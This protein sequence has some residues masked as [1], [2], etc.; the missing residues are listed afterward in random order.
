MVWGMAVTARSSPDRLRDSAVSADGGGRAM[1][2]AATAPAETAGASDSSLGAALAAADARDAAAR[3]LIA[4]MRATAA[5]AAA[6][7]GRLAKELG[8]V[9]AGAGATGA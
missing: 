6:L 4:V 9:T 3:A 7:A 2:R 5:A 1:R 8:M